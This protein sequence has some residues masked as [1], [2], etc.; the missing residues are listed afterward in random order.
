MVWAVYK[1]TVVHVELHFGKNLYC[2]YYAM[3]FDQNQLTL[4]FSP[5]LLHYKI[6]EAF[7][8]KL[9]NTAMIIMTLRYP[10]VKEDA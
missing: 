10:R 3:S 2:D 9:Y 1:L 7:F 5:G 6:L 4:N 8:E